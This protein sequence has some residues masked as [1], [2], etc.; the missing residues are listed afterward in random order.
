M[1]SG[2]LFAL[3]FVKPSGIAG[4]LDLENSAFVQA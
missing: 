2:I 1:E 3:R 4:R